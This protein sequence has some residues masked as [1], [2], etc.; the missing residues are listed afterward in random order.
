M[1]S[2]QLFYMGFRRYI[3]A[4]NKPQLAASC[5]NLLAAWRVG[6]HGGVWVAVDGVGQLSARVLA[7]PGLHIDRAAV[8][9]QKQLFFA[10]KEKK[11]QRDARG[12]E[13]R[14]GGRR[15]IRRTRMGVGWLIGIGR[16]GTGG[17]AR[18]GAFD[19]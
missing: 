12:R 16:D 5:G 7:R 10:K 1:Q 4:E 17:A 6:L 14:R 18:P 13:G 8:Y 9:H 19:E 11:H 3:G 2:H 15:R